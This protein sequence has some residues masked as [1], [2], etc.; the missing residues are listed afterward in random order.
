MQLSL[1]T[2]S[3]SPSRTSSSKD[4]HS[5]TFFRNECQG[6][7]SCII[8][9]PSTILPSL[10]CSSGHSCTCGGSL[11]IILT[12]IVSKCSPLLPI[13]NIRPLFWSWLLLCGTK[14]PTFVT[15]HEI[16]SNTYRSLVVWVA[17][18]KST[19]LLYGI[20]CK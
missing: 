20:L 17:D 19:P 11:A 9:Y 14:P 3:S 15:D 13:L 12:K 18:V 2:T 10:F 4:I 7:C 5:P 8:A 6:T 16:P 1:C